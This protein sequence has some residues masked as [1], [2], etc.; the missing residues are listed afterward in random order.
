MPRKPAMTNEQGKEAI[1]ML[2][3]GKTRREVETHFSVAAP[4]LRKVINETD[5]NFLQT[6]RKQKSGNGESKKP[7]MTKTK[8]KTKSP[9]KKKSLAKESKPATTG[10]S[11]DG[12]MDNAKEAGIQAA[13]DFE[14]AVE[15]FS[16]F[17]RL[18][19][20]EVREILINEA[21]KQDI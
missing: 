13:C 14:A 3:N 6:L 7:V 4:T 8:A 21:K 11:L 18:S 1:R 2:L 5:P 16:V 10:A 17:A 9:K 19:K 15:R 20:D 12:M